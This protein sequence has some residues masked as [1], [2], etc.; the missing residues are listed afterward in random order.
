MLQTLNILAE[1]IICN[2]YLASRTVNFVNIFTKWLT[3]IFQ[4]I[5][6]I[7]SLSNRS[8]EHS[9]GL[10]IPL[11]QIAMDSIQTLINSLN[12][13]IGVNNF[14]NILAQFSV[15]VQLTVSLFRFLLG[16]LADVLRGGDPITKAV[17]LCFQL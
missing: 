4:R 16:L 13:L 10:L 15:D 17:D 1:T 7:L 9:L 12:S 3:L 6:N 2:F 11:V 8:L 14:V 5:I